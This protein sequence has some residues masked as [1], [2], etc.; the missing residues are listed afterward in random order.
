MCT[1]LLPPGVNPV[2]VNKYIISYVLISLALA[3]FHV[4]L[5]VSV[6]VFLLFVCLFVF[7]VG[8]ETGL[9]RAAVR[10][11]IYFIGVCIGYFI[12]GTTVGLF[13]IT[14]L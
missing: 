2:A 4:A 14:G 7:C 1:V 3:T 10:F 11:V 6:R 8:C 12:F 9:V 5:I 13:G